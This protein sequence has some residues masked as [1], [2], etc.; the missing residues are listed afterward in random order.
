MNE[1]HLP[2]PQ[3]PPQVPRGKLWTALLVPPLLTGGLNLAIAALGS[4]GAL[5]SSGADNAIGLSMCLLPVGLLVIIICLIPF[6]ACLRVRYRGSSVVLSGFGYFIGQVVIC[7]AIWFGT[8]VAAY[9]GTK[10]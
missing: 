5:G 10:F 9:T 7:F 3:E 2:T 8:C 6:L 1:E 4:V